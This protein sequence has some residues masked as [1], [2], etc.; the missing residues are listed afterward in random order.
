MID[1][2]AQKDLS[3]GPL[4]VDEPGRRPDS[5]LKGANMSFVDG[6]N[7]DEKG[8]IPA[9]IQDHNSGK[10]LTLCYM[11][12]EALE[13]TLKE[14]KIYLFRRSKGKLMLKG[15]TSGCTQA[16]REVSIDCADNSILFRVE[17][18]RAACHEGYF[19]CY[20]RKLGPDGSFVVEDE[21]IFDPKEVYKKGK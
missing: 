4:I 13:K 7:F 21:R 8:L 9:I 5:L 15:E 18:E 11:N 19:T 3:R 14:G 6:L 10:V 17:Q 2:P 16:V 12:K 20:F 1:R